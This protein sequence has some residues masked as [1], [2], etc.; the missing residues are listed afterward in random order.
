MFIL[1]FNQWRLSFVGKDQ[2]YAAERVVVTC[3][4]DFCEF[5][6]ITIKCKFDQIF[7]L[8]PSELYIGDLPLVRVAEKGQVRDRRLDELIFESEL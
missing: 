1:C 8:R 3:D 4:L 2:L 7:R 5:W 6:F